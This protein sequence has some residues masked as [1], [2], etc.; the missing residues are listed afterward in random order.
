MAQL[1]VSITLA[2]LDAS[3][4]PADNVF[5][6]LLVDRSV[7][8]LMKEAY[9]IEEGLL[10]REGNEQEQYLRLDIVGGSVAHRRRI[11]TRPGRP[12]G[13]ERTPEEWEEVHEA[14]RAFL[15]FERLLQ[16]LPPR[17]R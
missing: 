11:R 6:G 7:S 3:D 9:A 13:R 15:Q 17:S 5:G 1:C 16:R 10:L 14:T 12:S 2:R 4:R 8:D